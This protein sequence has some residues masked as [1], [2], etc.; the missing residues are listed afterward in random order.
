MGQE[1]VDGPGDALQRGHAVTHQA[2]HQAAFVAVQE[3]AAIGLD[4]ERVD[5]LGAATGAIALQRPCTSP[6]CS[7]RARCGL[8]DHPGAAGAHQ[9][10]VHHAAA[11][12]QL[13]VA[14]PAQPGLRY[15][16]ALPAL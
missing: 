14:G 2:L 10:V 15:L 8:K 11:R 1:Q 7:S 9:H 13:G 5:L 6:W 16:S 12:A 4:V 3:A